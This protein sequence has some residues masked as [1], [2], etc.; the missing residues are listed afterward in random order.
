MTFKTGDIVFIRDVSVKSMEFYKIHSS[1]H[2]YLICPCRVP[3]NQ[4]MVVASMLSPNIAMLHYNGDTTKI[5]IVYTGD[6]VK[7]NIRKDDN[8]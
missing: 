2:S 4:S 8:I 5:T 6:I 7:A 3:K 1:R